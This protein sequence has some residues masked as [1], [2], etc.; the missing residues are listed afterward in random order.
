MGRILLEQANISDCQMQFLA[1]KKRAY[2]NFRILSL[3]SI[4]SKPSLWFFTL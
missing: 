3:P 1:E 4:F 2:K